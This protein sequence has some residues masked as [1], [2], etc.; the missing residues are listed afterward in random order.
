[1]ATST[2]SVLTLIALATELLPATP[3][4]TLTALSIIDSDI[5]MVH[6]R[7]M[8]EKVHCRRVGSLFRI[9]GCP[10]IVPVSKKLWFK[11]R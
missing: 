3:L 7:L 1:M 6:L 5:L 9:N 8:V 4:S 11:K 10:E 2:A